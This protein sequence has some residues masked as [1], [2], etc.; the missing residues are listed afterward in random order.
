MGVTTMVSRTIIA[1]TALLAMAGAAHA[2]DEAKYPDLGGLWHRV[3][4]H[5]WD[6]GG[7]RDAPLTPEYRAIYEKIRKNEA[8]NMIADPMLT[9]QAPGMPRIM[10]AYAPMEF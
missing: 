9:C 5:P 8:G 3:G 4:A 6:G 10:Q 7:H 2:F 1:L